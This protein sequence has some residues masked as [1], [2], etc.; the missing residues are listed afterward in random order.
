M[1]TVEIVQIDSS[2]NL[3]GYAQDCPLRDDP[4]WQTFVQLSGGNYGPEDR[5][6]YLRMRDNV[7]CS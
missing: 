6:Q 2:D 5:D 4:Y 1:A 3:G 7:S